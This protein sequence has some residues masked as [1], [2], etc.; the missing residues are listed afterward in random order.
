MGVYV[1]GGRVNGV[2]RS[3]LWIGR[4]KVR[5]EGL[6]V[7]PSDVGGMNRCRKAGS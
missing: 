1:R 2:G 7:V 5:W 6:Y 3:V 4:A